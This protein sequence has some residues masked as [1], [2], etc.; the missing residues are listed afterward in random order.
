MI[1]LSYDEHA[2]C[3]YLLERWKKLMNTFDVTV[4]YKDS[5]PRNNRHFF[6]I[7][8]VLRSKDGWITIK[9]IQNNEC[10]ISAD[11]IACIDIKYM[12]LS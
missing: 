9:D 7:V 10:W 3:L 2:I 8:S 12:E 6:D 5:T 11:I 1:D 4:S